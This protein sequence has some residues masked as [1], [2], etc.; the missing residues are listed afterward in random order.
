MEKRRV[1]YTITIPTSSL[2]N[3]DYNS[4]EFT[5][6]GLTQNEVK[7]LITNGFLDRVTEDE[8]QRIE[9]KITDQEYKDIIPPIGD[10]RDFCEQL[11]SIGAYIS[12]LVIDE[13]V[14][15]DASITLSSAEEI[16]DYLEKNYSLDYIPDFYSIEISKPKND[17]ED[18]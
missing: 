6:L 12:K 7:E 1:N 5:D 3:C 4:E 16:A 9:I 2:P 8:I 15:T 13:D 17:E 10:F 18:V 14:I 11:R